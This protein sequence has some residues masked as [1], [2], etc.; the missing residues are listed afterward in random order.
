MGRNSEKRHTTLKE[1][2]Q[3]P[4]FFLLIVPNRRLTLTKGH[5][6]ERINP[7]GHNIERRDTTTKETSIFSGMLSGIWE[8]IQNA[9]T[10]PRMHHKKP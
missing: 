7:K 5:N 3:Q 1:R 2:T 10:P 4:S 9:L 8:S 6:T